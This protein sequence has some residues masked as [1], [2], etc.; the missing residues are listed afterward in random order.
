MPACALPHSSRTPWKKLA[1]TA[2]G[3]LVACRKWQDSGPCAG[4]HTCPRW[5]SARLQYIGYASYPRTSATEI[6]V[7]FSTLL[8][9]MN[10]IPSYLCAKCRQRGKL[11]KATRLKRLQTFTCRVPT[12]DNYNITAYKQIQS[13]V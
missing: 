4:R 9:R 13:R 11:Y 7:A 8:C 5:R 3:V 10:K 12:H 6:A 1:V 2:A